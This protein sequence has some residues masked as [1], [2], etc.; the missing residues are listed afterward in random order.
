MTSLS[1]K[2]ISSALS[3]ALLDGDNDK[4]ETEG[5]DE[6]MITY[7]SSMLSE[8]STEDLAEGG[9]E[10]GGAVFDAISPFLESIELS[11]VLIA[12]ACRE[13]SS[14]ASKKIQGSN[15]VVRGNNKTNGFSSR[16]GG[17]KKL[18]K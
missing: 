2:E 5:L 1:E 3:S 13:V 16:E 17:T 12:K 11:S 8:L 7:L 15:T 9:E 18:T 14:L 10:E 4:E 6:D